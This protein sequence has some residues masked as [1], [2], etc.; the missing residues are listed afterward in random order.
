MSVLIEAYSVIVSRG[1]LERLYPG[2]VASY[3]RDSPNRTFCADPH[4]TRVGFMVSED[5]WYYIEQI[6]SPRGLTFLDG[7][8]CVDIA[9]ADPR[10]GSA[11][12]ASGSSTR[13]TSMGTGC[14]G[15][16]GPSPETWPR[17]RD[18]HRT[19]PR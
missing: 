6:L 15:S 17:P 7:G 18:G 2:G 3:E 11:G 14:A 10:Q 5:A 9:V 4:L 1:T 19:S 12:R 8:R 13:R 16:R